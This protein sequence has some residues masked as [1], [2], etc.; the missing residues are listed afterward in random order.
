MLTDRYIPVDISQSKC[1]C[2]KSLI[3]AHLSSIDLIQ[4]RKDNEKEDRCGSRT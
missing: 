1:T 4:T 2:N 3:A